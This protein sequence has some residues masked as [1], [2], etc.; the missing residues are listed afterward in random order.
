MRF[1]SAILLPGALLL[2][3]LTAFAA[4]AADSLTS[5]EAGQAERAQAAM[6]R[7][8]QH[9]QEGRLNEAAGLL[10]GF[11]IN[12]AES[13]LIDEAYRQLAHIYAEMDEPQLALNYL[14][15]LD[16]HALSPTD[17]LM[18]GRLKLSTGAVEEA[19]A[20]LMALPAESL[21][22]PDRQA[23][24]LLLA[25]GLAEQAQAQPALYFLYQALLTEGDV[26][27]NDVLARMHILMDAQMTPSELAE[28]AFMYQ[29]TSVALLAKLKLGWRALEE[30]Q[31]EQARQW[32]VQVLSGAVGFPYRDEALTLL[33]QVTDPSELQRAVGVLLPLSGRYAAFGKLVKR[34]MELAQ[35]DFRPTVPVRFLYYDTAGDPGLAAQQVAELAIGERVLAIVGPLVGSAAGAAVQ[36]ADQQQVPMLALSQKEGLAETSP[37]VFRNSLTAQLQV[38]TLVTYAMGDLGMTTFGILHP[39]TRQ[40]QIMADLFSVAVEKRGGLL[41][42][43]QSYLPE[44][45]DFRRQVRLLQGLDPD[46]PDEEDQP[47][48]EDPSAAV[49]EEQEPPPFE[50]L[51]V[52]DYADR[53]SLVAPQLPFYGLEGVQLL[54]TNGWNDPQLL[55][56]AGKFVEGA[57]FVDGFFRHS[58][59]PF[60]QEFTEKYFAVYGEEPTILEAQGYDAAG[61]MLTLLEDPR[62][63]SRAG[64]RWALSQ[65]PIYPGV[66]GAT[67]F[68]A[69]GE[70]VKTL[71]LLQVQDGIIVQIN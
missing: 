48:S 29:D 68:D 25:A 4:E 52:P 14:A 45:T 71:F 11:L 44:Q 59:Y 36:R 16:P 5:A 67:H 66:T 28:A 2:L 13:T 6:N 21:S 51:F 57:V 49:P 34:G 7:A 65:M 31:K 37:Y 1:R 69:Q 46:A 64:L 58:P 23:R 24:S 47:E 54:G 18:V 20:T 10:R 41:V 40:G 17:R 43:R 70:A 9:Y 30:G 33:S 42:E 60:V 62:T 50:A 22:L 12:H 19:V 15:E 26:A 8:L 32:V 27:P 63:G 3:L 55:K 61:I 35:D 38:E 39:E 56:S 53:I